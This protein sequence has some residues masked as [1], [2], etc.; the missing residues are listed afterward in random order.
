[1]ANAGSIIAIQVADVENFP[2]SPAA[3]ATNQRAIYWQ[4]PEGINFWLVAEAQ[5]CSDMTGALSVSLSSASSE[6]CERCQAVRQTN[7][8]QDSF[9]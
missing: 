9:R 6:R 5:R 2:R 7:A 8:C 4:S 3:F 1:M